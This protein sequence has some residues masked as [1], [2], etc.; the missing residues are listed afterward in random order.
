MTKAALLF[1]GIQLSFKV[2]DQAI[3]WAKQNN[4]SLVAVFLQAKKE[5][6]EGYIIPS[7]LNAAE[8]ITTDAEAEA[9]HHA[10]VENNIV[11]LKH[12]ASATDIEICTTIMANPSEEKLQEE[13]GGCERLFAGKGIATEG[14]LSV[15]SINLD[16]WLADS[17][18]PVEMIDE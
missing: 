2:V 11:L 5:P 9:G 14:I 17:T 16:K 10:I 18:I 3:R 7:D 13:L 12:Q 6:K 4:G 1:N 15:D 8:N